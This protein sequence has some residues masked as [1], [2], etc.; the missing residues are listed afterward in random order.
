M[1]NLRPSFHE[2]SAIWLS[3]YQTNRYGYYTVFQIAYAR[4]NRRSK[5]SEQGYISFRFHTDTYTSRR[6]TYIDILQSRGVLSLHEFIGYMVFI[7][8]NS[9][10][11]MQASEFCKCYWIHRIRTEDRARAF[12]NRDIFFLLLDKHIYIRGMSLF[13]LSLISLQYHFDVFESFSDQCIKK[14]A[15]HC[16]SSPD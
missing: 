7:L 2:L 15:H 5:F 3:R 10:S 16:E 9:H 6:Q 8:P 4:S 13:S 14:I 1:F 12:Q 11:Y